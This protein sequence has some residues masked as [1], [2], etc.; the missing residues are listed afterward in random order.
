VPPFGTHHSK[1]FLLFYKCWHPPQSPEYEN[2]QLWA[3]RRCSL[4]HLQH[5]P[6]RGHFDRK[7]DTRRLGSEISGPVVQ[8]QHPF[9]T[10]TANL[11]CDETCRSQTPYS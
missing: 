4:L 2:Q 1:F 10:V 5:L 3:L 8:F 7:S 6:P 9:A 11:R